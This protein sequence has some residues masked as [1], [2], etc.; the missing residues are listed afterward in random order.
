MYLDTPFL[1]QNS[2][3]CYEVVP[4]NKFLCLFLNCIFGIF[5]CILTLVR[6]FVTSVRYVFTS[7]KYSEI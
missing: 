2:Y 6:F 1:I 4:V 7:S 3:I 5:A